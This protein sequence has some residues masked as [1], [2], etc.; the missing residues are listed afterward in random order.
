[1]KNKRQL[2]TR[3]IIASKS[4]DVIDKKKKIIIKPSREHNNKNQK[5]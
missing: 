5:K 4:F 1:M 3:I 2:T